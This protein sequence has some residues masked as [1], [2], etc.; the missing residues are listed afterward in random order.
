MFCHIK[1][2]DGG[3]YMK[4]N[5]SLVDREE[6]YAMFPALKGRGRNPHNRLNWLIRNRALKGLVKVGRRIYFDPEQIR[7]WIRENQIPAGTMEKEGK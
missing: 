7:E 3:S 6:L 4:N 1:T 2:N 5:V